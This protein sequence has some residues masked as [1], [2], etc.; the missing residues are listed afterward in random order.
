MGK[1]QSIEEFYRSKMNWIPENQQKEIGHFNVFRS[2]EY[3]GCSPKPVPYNRKDFF[4]ISLIIGKNRV[5]YADKA[6]T[7]EKQ[8]LLFANPMV[9]Y[10]WEALEEQQSGFFCIFTETF[11][12]H[13]GAMRDYPVFQ[14]GCNPVFMLD[15]GQLDAVRTIFRQML[16]EIGSDYVY[17]YDVLRNLVFNL[18]HLALKMQPATATQH[19]GLNAATRV[20]SLFMELLERQFPVESPMQQ[21]RLHTPLAYAEQL[22][23]HVNHLNRSLKA[24]TGKTTSQLIAER[25]GQEARILLK[26]TDWNIS[27]IAW[28]LGFKDLPAFINFFRKSMQQSPGAFREQVA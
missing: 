3:V 6:V 7:I 14:P 24:V 11:F 21:V 25:M 2:D 26:H 12:N 16:E 8:A 19:R 23:V 5:H 15:D 4:K 28:C 20:S 10:S 13:F 22:A 17:K 27:E 1:P 18:V 9:P